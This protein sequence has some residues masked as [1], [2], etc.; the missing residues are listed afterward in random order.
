MKDRNGNKLVVGGYSK[1]G[2]LWLAVAGGGGRVDWAVG[3]G[4]PEKKL[5]AGGP[6][7]MAGAAADRRWGVVSGQRAARAGRG[8]WEPAVRPVV[9]GG[10]GGGV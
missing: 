4:S 8:R 2:D 3:W 1:S 6:R 10:S 9:A 5:S 7:G